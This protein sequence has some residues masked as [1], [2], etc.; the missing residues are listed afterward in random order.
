[1]VKNGYNSFSL[2]VRAMDFFDQKILTSLKDGKPKDFNMLLAQ[3]S[4][5][6]NTLQEHLRHLTAQGLV[7]KEKPQPKAQARP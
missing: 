6:H 2:L 1:M 7:V 3:V 4:F 5:S